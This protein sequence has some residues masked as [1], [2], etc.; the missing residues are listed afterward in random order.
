MFAIVHRFRPF[1]AARMHEPRRFWPFLIDL[2]RRDVPALPTAVEQEMLEWVNRFRAYPEAEFDRYYQTVLQHD[3][4]VSYL[5]K[6]PFLPIDKPSIE[7]FRNE[8]LATPAVPPL[9]WNTKLNDAARFHTD[10]MIAA[11]AFDHNLPGEP[12]LGSRISNSGYQAWYWGENIAYGHGQIR[13]SHSS[14]VHSDGHRANLAFMNFTEIGIASGYATAA[15]K[16][17]FDPIVTQDFGSRFNR[18]ASV[19]GVIFND[20]VASDDFY[21]AGEGLQGVS[22]TLSGPQGNFVTT[23]WGSGGYQFDDVPAGTYR[24]FVSSPGI[25]SE[26]Y[27]YQVTVGPANVKYDFEI[28][29]PPTRTVGFE[30]VDAKTVNEGGSA[31]FALVRTGP[32]DSALDVTIFPVDRPSGSQ[33]WTSVLAPLADSGVVRFQPGQSRATFQVVALQDSTER[34]DI[35]V[36][37]VFNVNDPGYATIVSTASITILDDDRPRVSI[38]RLANPGAVQIV[39]ESEKQVTLTLLRSGD[40]S[41]RAVVPFSI[42]PVSGQTYLAAQNGSFV[43]EPGATQ[44]VKS[45]AIADDAIARFDAVFILRLG[46]PTTAD[47]QI[48]GPADQVVSVIDDDPKPKLVRVTGRRNRQTLNALTALFDAPLASAN[49]KNASIWKITEAGADGIFDTA[50]DATIAL[51]G[52]TYKAST[53]TFTLNFR[54]PSK[55]KTA[56]SYR[57]ALD[58][59]KLST[60]IGTPL[61][62][63]IVW[64]VKV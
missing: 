4:S 19:I 13:Y 34:A 63:P 27:S 39:R 32:L 10:F 49:T 14:L 12:E 55:S 7:E 64:T 53:R 29:S 33:P 38:V 21:Q 17:L 9:A 45:F 6:V 50:D 58:A 47:T 36:D 31:T 16:T 40:S 24:L 52:A 59:A 28:G 42:V 22:I 43:F 1:R 25:D 20:A 56:R 23:S 60:P 3:G 41:K 44:S 8:L 18:Q 48:E 35:S 15:N 37:F 11:D 30:T 61:N 5:A 54:T 51:R 26:A 2:E 57:I 46:A 62:G